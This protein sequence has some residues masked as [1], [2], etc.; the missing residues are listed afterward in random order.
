MSARLLFA[1]LTGGHHDCLAMDEGFGAGDH[2]FYEKAQER[3]TRFLRSAGTLLLASHSEDL[4]S[5]FVAAAVFDSGK[6][7]SRVL[8]SKPSPT[9]IGIKLKGEARSKSVMNMYVNTKRQ[10]VLSTV[11]EAWR[12]RRAWW[13][14][15]SRTRARFA[16][17]F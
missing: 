11:S 12:I 6:L 2:S 9:T 4:C 10:S 8:L 16:R 5:V 3:M 13:F 1:V 7:V 15:T 14:V 17:T